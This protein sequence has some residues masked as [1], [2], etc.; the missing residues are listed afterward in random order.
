M[1]TRDQGSE[2]RDQGLDHV[3]RMLRSALQPVGNER[4][5]ERDLWP[6]MLRRMDNEASRGPGRVPWFDWALGGAL[7]TFAVVAPH[8]IPVIL[9]YL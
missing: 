7:L 9:Y 8:T 5:P 1:K 4:E 2:I 3:K 6:A